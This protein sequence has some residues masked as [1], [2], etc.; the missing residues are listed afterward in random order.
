MSAVLI[1]IDGY[2][3]VAGAPVT[4]RASSV[5]DD[6][7]CHLNGVV[8]WPA[9]ATLPP[10]RYDF[11][12]G[13]FGGKIET[14]QSSLALA[15]EAWPDF[16][17]Y[18]L[19]DA[20]IRLWTGEAGDAWG[21]FLLRKDGRLSSQPTMANGKASVSFAVDDRWLDTPLL[22]TYA[23][24]TGAEGEAAQKGQPKPLAVGAPRYVP[25]QLV[26]S[27]NSVVQLSAYGEIEGVEVA[28]ERLVRFEA[29]IGD[30][31]SYAALA[32]ATIPAGKWATCLAEGFV[33]HGA[34]PAGKLSYLVKGD[35]AGPDGWVRLPGSVIKR[36]ALLS[37][38]AGKINEAS[39][40][41]LDAARPWNISVY[42]GEQTTAREL[43]QRIAASVN[44]VAGVD[45][46][47]KLFIAPV[48]FSAPLM[49]LDATGAALPPVESVEQLA[50]DAP[51]W[52]LAIGA[53]PT[54]AVHALSEVA[55]VYVDRGRY[56]PDESYR[57]GHIVDLA[58]GSRWRYINAAAS[59]GNAPPAPPATSNAWWDRLTP[60]TEFADIPGLDDE[61]K[62]KTKTW[63]GDT[64]PSLEESDP[65]DVWLDPNDKD[66][67]WLRA[68]RRLMVGASRLVIG[69]SYLLL[70]SGWYPADGSVR[71]YSQDD[72]PANPLPGTRWH[73]PIDGRELEWDPVLSNWFPIADV[74][75]L[76]QVVASMADRVI[77]TDYLGAPVTDQIPM[78][79][80]PVVTLGGA[81]VR[82]SDRLSYSIL[83][84]AGGLAGHLSVENTDGS[85]DKGRVT[86]SDYDGPGT[87]D[88]GISVDGEAITPLRVAIGQSSGAAPGTGAGPGKDATVSLEAGY[89]TSSYALIAATPEMT[90]ATGEEA[91]VA[92]TAVYSVAGYSSGSAQMLGK[93][94]WSVAGSGVWTDFTDGAVTGS[95]ASFDNDYWQ[96]SP[97][98]LGLSQTE[99]GLAAD[100]YIFGFWAARSGTRNLTISPGSFSVGIA[101]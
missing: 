3:P 26:D 92:L 1:Q 43:I 11:F 101:P 77:L 84:E 53:E 51:F 54:W 4:L 66:R 18:I 49:T 20:R 52:R 72:P 79:L 13:A 40:A 60:P 95:N 68:S 78:V 76:N 37:G 14:P 91:T 15:V 33:R 90:L 82:T 70:G 74:T 99:T 100:T 16:G 67:R 9:L 31:A 96:S 81:D 32:A 23:G 97:G 35:K 64:P 36:I 7:V 94:R 25:G 75:S 69:G 80:T 65:N 30:Y 5:D 27:I 98:Y 38:G 46:L 29:S 56:D 87:F 24:T 83:A 59:T 50:I 10:L 2:D 47:G 34:P 63:R 6:R 71:T 41:A 44:A 12:D 17:R 93:M 28:L 55:G 85:D 58:D 21:S 89:V 42:Q 48:A 62:E 39:V 19:A 88:L 73:R 86:L 8:W 45:W 61:L 57:D 22:T